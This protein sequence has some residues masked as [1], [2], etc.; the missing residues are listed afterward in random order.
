MCSHIG[1]FNY[2]KVLP[3]NFKSCESAL[4]DSMCAVLQCQHNGQ[5]HT[6]ICLYTLLGEALH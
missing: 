1:H 6:D 4:M 5:T 3:T 2:L